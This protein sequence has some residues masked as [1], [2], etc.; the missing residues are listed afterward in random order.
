MDETRHDT[1][2]SIVRIKRKAISL[3]NTTTETLFDPPRGRQFVVL[4]AIM[5]IRQHVGT[6]SDQPNIQIDNGTNGQDIV[7]AVDSA[8]N[9]E[10]SI[11]RLTVVGNYVVDWSKPL[12]LRKGDA[13]NGST[14][15]KVDLI[16]TL[17]E[18]SDIQS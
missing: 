8:G 1:N 9:V 3:L 2:D 16:I 15:Y 18:I 10:G 14:T 7:A 12:R 17:L 6:N 5:Q 13:A 11:Q 4:D